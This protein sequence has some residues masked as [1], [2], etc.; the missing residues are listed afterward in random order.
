MFYE[1]VWSWQWCSGRKLSG[2]AWRRGCSV[3][4]AACRIRAQR[5]SGEQERHEGLWRIFL[6]KPST[7]VYERPC[8]HSLLEN[9]FSVGDERRRRLIA[10]LE[11]PGV[12]SEGAGGHGVHAELA[13]QLVDLQVLAA[14][15]R[16]E[17]LALDGV[18][19]GVD[20]VRH[21]LHLARGEDGS[22]GASG[23]NGNV[24]EIGC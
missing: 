15:A 1:V 24:V 6:L 13:E 18:G 20:E 8:L 2:L 4:R 16:V 10:L 23:M 9:P 19:G 7:Y 21:Q 5:W 22:E 11:R 17:D 12:H 14:V 3:P